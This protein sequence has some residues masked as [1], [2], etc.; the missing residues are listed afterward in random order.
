MW[1]TPGVCSLAFYQ[2]IFL[3][4]SAFFNYDAEADASDD[5]QTY[6][7]SWPIYHFPD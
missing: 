6:I 3:E 5:C 4:K 7:Y 2:Y 1:F